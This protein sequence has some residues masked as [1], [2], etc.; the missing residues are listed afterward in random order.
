LLVAR[1]SDA[2]RG[3]VASAAAAAP[4]AAFDA[5]SVGFEVIALA[6]PVL[7]GAMVASAVTSVVQ[8][9]GFI[10][11]KKLTPKV[12][13]LNV[14]KGLSQLVS[15]ARAFAVVRA[16]LYSAFVA[17]V[18]C[19]ALLAHVL[20]VARACG[21]LSYAAPV[22]G[23]IAFDLARTVA[24]AGI[25]L[26][27]VDIVVVRRGWRKRLRMSKDEVKREHKESEGDPQLKAARERA[28][29]EMLAAA[30]IASVKTASV[31]V[32]NPTHVACA[33]RYDEKEGDEAPVVIA[34][35]EGE[36]AAQIVRAARQYGVPVLHDVPLARAL[37]ELQVG[38]TIPET[39]YEAVAEILQEAWRES[40]PRGDE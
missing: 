2:L 32:V 11:T 7:A 23:T 13:R 3:A 21:R 24:L 6:T 1:A 5:A 36:L 28:H 25:G 15:G 10:A 19:R 39:L 38:D 20:D 34:S 27:V 33:L 17:Y 4:R 16:L 29:H 14:F 18:A 8:T 37:I 31:V 40:P 30:T 12:E 35:G 9:G 22:A 26:A